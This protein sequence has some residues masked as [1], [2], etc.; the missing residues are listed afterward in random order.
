LHIQAPGK[1]D[2]PLVKQWAVHATPTSFILDK[3]KG[4]L[5]KVRNF[6]ELE[7]YLNQKITAFKKK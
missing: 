6:N 2:D 3:D 7:L 5:A 1:W 4:I